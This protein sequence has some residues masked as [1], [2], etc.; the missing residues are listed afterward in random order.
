MALPFEG[1]CVLHIA[2]LFGLAASLVATTFMITTPFYA[3]AKVKIEQLD[4]PQP[5][6]LPA[7]AESERIEKQ[8]KIPT[9]NRDFLNIITK[10]LA[11]LERDP[12]DAGAYIDL[13][14]ANRNL[15]Q[16]R[17]GLDYCNKAIELNGEIPV[18]YGERALAYASLHQPEKALADLERAI[19]LDP[20]NSAFYSNRGWIYT[21]QKHY[22]R[23]IE[24]CTKSIEIYAGYSPAF[25]C[26][27]R[28]YLATGEFEKAIADLT[29]AI[30]LFPNQEADYYKDRAFAYICLHQYP[31]AL[32]DLVVAIRLKP[33]DQLAYVY[34]GIAM[35]KTG[36]QEDAV[37]SLSSAI[38]L[39]DKNVSALKNRAVLY[40]IMR[41]FDKSLFDLNAALKI[42]PQ[43][44][45]IFSELG[46][47]YLAMN[48]TARA[49]EQFA[50]AIAL[51]P[52]ETEYVG[53]QTR[54][55]AHVA[56][57]ATAKDRVPYFVDEPVKS[58]PDQK[59]DWKSMIARVRQAKIVENLPVG[60]DFTPFLQR[61]L[62]KY[63]TDHSG[64]GGT[65]SFE[66]LRDMATLGSA[67]QPVFFCWVKNSQSDETV[68]E[69]AVRLEAQD[70]SGFKITHFI[71]AADIAADPKAIFVVFPTP[72]SIDIL[73]RAKVKPP[74]APLN[75]V[76]PQ[77]G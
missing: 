47:T 1:L 23:A 73:L 28:A 11:T 2:R 16:Y 38:E 61:D 67:G 4:V 75:V 60:Q 66:L 13:A 65:T 3:A 76:K 58:S 71:K 72:V 40:R 63:F 14:Y 74:A 5:A 22:V 10:S 46:Q 15:D 29:E 7:T 30:K 45:T 41:E 19:K 77:T 39:N 69:G 42:A 27:S 33:N 50:K 9:S 56:P 34:K 25:Y 59:T 49:S 64:K 62:N 18:A 57:M 54:A 6:D 55:Q 32:N 44:D 21:N 52:D 12:K 70:K 24:E 53:L 48:D 68:L 26:R 51:N 20:N 8:S 37:R 17:K 43:D 35:S 36:A 31:Q